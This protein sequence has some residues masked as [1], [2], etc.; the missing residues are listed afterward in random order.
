MGK[1]FVK[2]MLFYLSLPWRLELDTN[3]EAQ[4]DACKTNIPFLQIRLNH[5]GHTVS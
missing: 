5:D 2:R 1:C 4:L 3:L